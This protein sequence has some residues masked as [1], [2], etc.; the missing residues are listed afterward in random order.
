MIGMEVMELELEVSII[1]SVV[2][3]VSAIGTAG[4]Q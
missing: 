3:L 2:A 1:T 4:V